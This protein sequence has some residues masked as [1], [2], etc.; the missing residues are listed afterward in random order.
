M[1]ALLLETE[2]IG[3]A[4]IDLLDGEEDPAAAV[5]RVAQEGVNAAEGEPF[6]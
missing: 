6:F 4:W 3:N 5:K 2:G 1:A